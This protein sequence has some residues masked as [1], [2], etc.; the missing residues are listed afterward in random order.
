MNTIIEK[1]N[2]I[3][4]DILHNFAVKWKD[5]ECKTTFRD[6]VKKFYGFEKK[7]GWNILLN[8]FY[9]IDDTELAKQSFKKFE[10][11]GPSRH[12]DIGERYLRLYGLLNAIYQQKLAIQNLLEIY[13][14]NNKKEIIEKLA[15]LELIDLRNKIGAH[16]TNFNQI[17]SDSEHIFDVYE[18][19][20][21]DL[22][23][24]EIKLLRNQNHFENFDLDKM[25]KSFD[26]EIEQILCLMIGK[27]IK[28]L[29]NNQGKLFEKYLT[30]N[31]L[32]DGIMIIKNGNKN[33]VIK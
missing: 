10:L 13:K 32:R 21:P 15:N 26:K 20:R 9:I 17:K 6:D 23:T 11:H 3:Q 4:K 31:E 30:I 1:Y 7:F 33:I 18:I 19:S 22:E 24:G 25:I 29:F 27:V 8:A 12:K 28:K 14:I 2:S 5:E 16:S